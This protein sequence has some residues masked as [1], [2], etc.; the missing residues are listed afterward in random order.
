MFDF[1]FHIAHELDNPTHIFFYKPIQIGVNTL[2]VRILDKYNIDFNKSYQFYLNMGGANFSFFA[3]PLKKNSEDEV[4]FL[5]QESRIELRKYPRL[6]T[7]SLNIKVFVRTLEGTLADISLG[8]C[9][10]KFNGKI[11]ASFFEKGAK[12]TLS[13][14]IPSE[15]K[16]VDL[17]GFIVNVNPKD[18][19]VSFAFEK[20]DNKVLSVYKTISDLLKKGEIESLS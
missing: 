11:P 8:G 10:V 12:A 3:K 15:S 19:A 18:N 20:Q 17:S 2:K 5:I 7:D 4:E 14:E 1:E 9:K 6:K 13:V 16:Q